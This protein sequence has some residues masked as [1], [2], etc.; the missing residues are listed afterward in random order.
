M[1]KIRTFLRYVDDYLRYREFYFLWHSIK[2]VLLKSGN[3]AM[4]L[5]KS[6]LGTF[7]TRTGTLDFQFLN[8]DYEWNVK[9][10]ILSHYKDY[11]LFLDIGSNVG[12]YSFL[13]AGKGIPCHAFE[14]VKENYRSLMMNVMV[15]NVENFISIHPFGLGKITAEVDFIFETKN[16]GASHIAGAHT[17][18]VEIKGEVGKRIKAE[19]KTLDSVMSTINY[20]KEDKILIKID[21]EGMEI[22]V[23]E[24]GEQFLK[25]HPH[26]M[27]VMESKHSGADT[28]KE[29]LKNHGNFIYMEV[30]K[31]NMAI[32]K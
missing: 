31:D 18:Y 21:A 7:I 3:P 9:R 24:G 27:I 20:K 17:D 14:P 10:F 28:I 12:T 23:L 4:R 29:Y 2:Y 32:M 19:I 16:T 6:S 1:S 26:F 8:Y 30:D 22:D 11:N 15:N 25:N 5:Y 13:I